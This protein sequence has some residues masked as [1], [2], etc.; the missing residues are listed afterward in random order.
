MFTYGGCSII[1]RELF[2]NCAERARNIQIKT[3]GWI[4]KRAIESGRTEFWEA[5]RRAVIKESDFD[6]EGFMLEYYFAAQEVTNKLEWARTNPFENVWS[7]SFI[8]LQPIVLPKASDSLFDKYCTRFSERADS[9][10]SKGYFS[11][12]AFCRRHLEMIDSERV[13]VF[14]VDY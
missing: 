11:A 1:K 12:D 3:T 14:I 9:N 5:W 2:D 7:C 13:A 10:I 8:F 6:H 4:F